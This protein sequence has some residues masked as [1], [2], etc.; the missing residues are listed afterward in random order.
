MINPHTAV[1]FSRESTGK[2]KLDC[3]VPSTS[4][5]DGNTVESVCKNGFTFPEAGHAFESGNI[6]MDSEDFASG[7]GALCRTPSQTTAT[8]GSWSLSFCV[9]LSPPHVLYTSAFQFLLCS[10]AV[11]RPYV[12][13][14]D[15]MRRDLPAGYDSFYVA[16]TIDRNGDGNIS[17][18][19]YSVA[20][21]LAGRPPEAYKH[22]YIVQNPA[23]V[24]I[25]GDRSSTPALTLCLLP[26][27]LCRRCCPSTSFTSPS[28]LQKM[29]W[30]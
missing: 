9:M 5:L 27:C 10:V 7:N 25:R 19:E 11:G 22:K 23:Q 28:T 15:T 30:P 17:N 13:D 18:E 12:V 26:C 16:P 2:L 4:L 29:K 1:P 8:L 21:M 6:D 24:G 14:H 20:A 3:W